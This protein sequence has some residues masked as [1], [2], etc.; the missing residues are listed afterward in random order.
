MTL[1]FDDDL[2]FEDSNGIR[3]TTVINCWACELPANGCPSPNSWPYYV[4]SVREWLEFISGHGVAL[5]D[6]RRRLKAALSAYSVYR[7]QGPIKHRFEASTWNQN[8]GILAGFYKWAKDE[9][10]ADSEPFTYRQAV[11]AFKGQVRRGR[12]NQS[13]RRQARRRRHVPRLVP[14]PS[15]S[16]HPGGG[17]GAD[18]GQ[19]AKCR[20]NGTRQ[21]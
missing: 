15:A 9:E 10:Y 21:R 8:M 19:A 20:I 4:R 6:S 1:L 3:P 14:M 5:F 16:A 18:A 11:W 2:L 7:A 17:S 12:V 13:R